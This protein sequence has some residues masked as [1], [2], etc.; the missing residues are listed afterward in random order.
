MKLPHELEAHRADL[1]DALSA[2][3]L[4]AWPE[5]ESYVK[6]CGPHS[7]AKVLTSALHEDIRGALIAV[8]YRENMGSADRVKLGLATK[9]GAK[10]RFFAPVDFVIEINWTAWKTLSPEQKIALVD[11]E[12]SHCGFDVDKEAFTLVHHDV[13]EFGSIVRRWGLWKP[14]LAKFQLAMA[15]RQIDLFGEPEPAE[16][17][18]EVGSPS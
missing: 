3:E 6:A 16:E 18:Q 12:L 17:G 2:P 9:A 15:A 7:I 8:L 10:L 4:A 5:G 13:E 14:D 1:L 11:H